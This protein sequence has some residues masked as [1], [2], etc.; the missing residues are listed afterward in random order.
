MEAERKVNRRGRLEN[1]QKF[2]FSKRAKEKLSL[3]YG[4]RKKPKNEKLGEKLDG[5]AR[6][7]NIYKD[8]MFYY[9]V[10]PM[11]PLSVDITITEQHPLFCATP[12]DNKI[13][14]CLPY[15]D[16]ESFKTLSFFFTLKKR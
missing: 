16:T 1:Q 11:Q 15:E 13:E 3:N 10:L 14:L 6:G 12:K 4:R 9:V 8:F 7:F 5:G 2:E